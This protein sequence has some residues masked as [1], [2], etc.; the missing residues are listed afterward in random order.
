ME[1]YIKVRNRTA[2]TSRVSFQAGN[3]VVAREKKKKKNIE[4]EDEKNRKNGE[5]V[6]RYRMEEGE[7]TKKKTGKNR[8]TVHGFAGENSEL[9]SFS[10]GHVVRWRVT[11]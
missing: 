10:I 9:V 8:H 7:K 1:K 4:E 3:D 11:T 5:R 2:I 6:E